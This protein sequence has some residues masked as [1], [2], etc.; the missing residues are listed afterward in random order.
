M[1]D[2]GRG[3]RRG[4]AWGASAGLAVILPL[5]AT[6]PTTSARAEE[7]AF[8]DTMTGGWGGVRSALDD[9]GVSIGVTYTGEALRTLSGGARQGTAFEGLVD[10]A[11][12]TDLEK[13]A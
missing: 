4:V 5:A 1:R 6:A 11:V 12:E 7:G 8:A 2:R 9:R 13:L 10:I 3:R